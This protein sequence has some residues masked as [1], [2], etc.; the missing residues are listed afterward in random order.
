MLILL[1]TVVQLCVATRYLLRCEAELICRELVHF[2]I[3]FTCIMMC[4]AYG[5]LGISLS[6]FSE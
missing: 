5:L 3:V 1:L 4:T 2:V 6:Y